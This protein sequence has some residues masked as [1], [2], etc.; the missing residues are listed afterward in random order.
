MIRRLHTCFGVLLLAGLCMA[1]QA[2][3]CVKTVRWSDD[4][5]YSLMG[6]DGQVHGIHPD[7]VRE[8]LLR[9]KCTPQFVQLPWARAVQE[10]KAGRLDL[11]PNAAKT[12]EREEFAHFSRILN[13]SRNVLFVRRHAVTATALKELA[14]IVGTQFRLGVQLGATYG[15]D[16]EKMIREPRFVE[17]LTQIVAL[18]SGWEMMQKDRLDGQ[19][20]DELTGQTQLQEMG[21]S[22][23]IVVSAVVTSSGG[24][25]VAFSKLTSDK[26][27]VSRFNKALESMMADGTYARLMQKNLGC[28]IS[29]EKLGCR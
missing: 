1:A 29:V 21:L 7:L 9:M 10:L 24:D 18:K 8:A 16:Y 27:Y 3:E 22:D 15:D 19:L 5:P 4:A 13:R 6:P 2:G 14:D 11:L 26:D 12:P 17:R 28:K 23:L 20:A 25:M